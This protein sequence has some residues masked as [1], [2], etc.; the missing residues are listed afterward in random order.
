MHSNATREGAIIKTKDTKT[1]TLAPKWDKTSINRLIL[2]TGP[3]SKIESL[4]FHEL[5]GLANKQ[6]CSKTRYNAHFL[7]KQMAF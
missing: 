4:A 1:F 6:A 3:N 5:L 2:L 7:R